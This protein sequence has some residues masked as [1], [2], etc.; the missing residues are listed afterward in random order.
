M[1]F[2]YKIFLIFLFAL[3]VAWGSP[4]IHIDTYDAAVVRAILD[5][6]GWNSVPVE[7]VATT[8]IMS[9]AGS[10]SSRILELNLAYRKGLPKITW[11]PAAVGD[12]PEL[13]SLL[14]KGNSVAE[15]PAALTTLRKLKQL[16]CSSNR[17]KR[18]P[19]SLGGLPLQR[20]D[21]SFNQI[22]S[23]DLS[24]GGFASL[25]VFDMDHNLLRSLPESIGGLK[26]LHSASFASNTLTAIPATVSMLSNLTTMNLDSN[27]LTTL[28]NSIIGLSKLK[29]DVSGNMICSLETAV[30]KWLDTCHLTPDWKASQLCA[31]FVIE[32]I[33]SDITT[34]TVLHVTDGASVTAGCAPMLIKPIEASSIVFP[35]RR[36]LK[37]VEVRFNDCL[38]AEAR[39][40]F[41]ITFSWADI[42]DSIGQA[43][44]LSIYFINSS[45]FEYLGGSENKGNF[46]ISITSS[47]P[48]KYLLT[49]KP[50]SMTARRQ[51]RQS[52]SVGQLLRCTLRDHGIEASFDLQRPSLVNVRLLTLQGRLVFESKRLFQAG[53][54]EMRT[55]LPGNLRR[56]SPFVVEIRTN[57]FQSSCIVNNS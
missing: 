1:R 17:L 49:T 34:G 4:T 2:C 22:D 45:D 19:D 42:K 8:S 20:L 55:I 44:D 46:T 37:A 54:H 21:A 33:I 36:V 26:Q 38:T 31:P 15:L 14:I 40:N 10:T 3:S 43:P 39:S 11:I 48:G 25:Q 24:S 5:S 18:F 23:L 9:M 51:G 27:Q 13:L 29:I 57:E 16:D 53:S 47:R 50:Q 52:I 56:S 41:L 12:L 28:P 32:S 7:S 6:V 35:E 30:S